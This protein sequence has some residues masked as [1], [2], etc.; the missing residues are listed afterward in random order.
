MRIRHWIAWGLLV[1]VILGVGGVA[2][3]FHAAGYQKFVVETGSMVPTLDPG[4]LVVDRPARGDFHVGD[5]IT[6]RHGQGNDL[7][8]HRIVEITPQGI[9]TKGDANRTADAWTIP[10]D[11]VVGVVAFHIPKGGYVVTF[12]S[13]PAGIGAVA[14]ALVALILLWRLFFPNEDCE[15]GEK[16]DAEEAGDSPDVGVAATSAGKHEAVSD[17]AEGGAPLP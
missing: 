1:F 16:H 17:D 14:L 13:Q 4:D 10:D 6:F 3:G 7:V 15:P 9:K 5:I 12:L 8:T 2:Y 11:F